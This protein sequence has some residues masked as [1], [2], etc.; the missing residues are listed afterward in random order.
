MLKIENLSVSHGAIRALHEISFNVEK[1]QLAAVIGANGAGKTTL[2][3]TLSGLN[4]ASHGTA[5]WNDHNILH[6]KPEALV[7]HGISHVSEGKSVIPELT[8]AENLDL[9]ALWRRNRK[10]AAK[11]KQEV[12]ELFPRLGERLSQRADS[13]SGGERQMLAIGRSIMSKPELL[14]L[15]EPSLGLAPLVIEQ[16]FQAIRDLTTAMGL[17]VLLVEQ[18]AMGALKIADIGI[19]L[20]LGSIAATGSAAALKDDP[21]VRAAYLG[22]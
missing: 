13:L 15:D 19:V 6:A 1:G 8:V 21:A 4:K 2:L 18:N 22:F 11:S 7:R 17:T 5:H 3:R 12:V 9:G 10:E 14:L 16:I 20:N